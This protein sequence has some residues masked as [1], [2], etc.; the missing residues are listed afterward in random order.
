LSEH[1]ESK[2]VHCTKRLGFVSLGLFPG[3]CHRADLCSHFRAETTQE[4][5]VVCSR[6]DDKQCRHSREQGSRNRSCAHARITLAASQTSH[7]NSVFKPLRNWA[8]AEPAASSCLGT[9]TAYLSSGPSCPFC[10]WR[11]ELSPGRSCL[12][13]RPSHTYLSHGDDAL[14][15][16]ETFQDRLTATGGRES[17]HAVVRG[18]RLN[19]QCIFSNGKYNAVS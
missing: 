6:R 18:G 4:R 14:V 15:L 2:P 11:D 3:S 5:G 10:S 1:R 13:I 12:S 19:T 7:G 8:Q 16:H 9:N 17:Y